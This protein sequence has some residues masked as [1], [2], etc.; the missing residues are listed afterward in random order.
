M[1][2]NTAKARQSLQSASK[3]GARCGPRLA[4]RLLLDAGLTA[5]HIPALVKALEERED[6]RDRVLLGRMKLRFEGAEAALTELK[7]VEAGEPQAVT[8]LHE[9]AEAYREMGQLESASKIAA[10]GVDRTKG[11]PLL[12]AISARLARESKQLKQAE[13][14]VAAGLKMHRSSPQ[15]NLERAAILAA[16]RRYPEA[17][18]VAN[19]AMQPGPHFADAACLRANVQLRRGDREGAQVELRRNIA[20]SRR[21]SGV[22][23]QAG[24]WACLVEFHLKRGPSA[25]TRAKTAMFYLRRFALQSST[26][27]YLDGQVALRDNRPSDALSRFRMAIELDPVHREAWRQVAKSGRLTAA[28]RQRFQKIFPGRQPQ[29]H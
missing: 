1:D 26:I 23:A 20:P 13:Q 16:Q 2:G 8:V 7:A 22:A 21:H 25:L 11:H 4:G 29:D 10:L 3:A 27:E 12:V 14:L 9:L 28:E 6:A 19:E 5:D 24:I 18:A 17:E 15:L